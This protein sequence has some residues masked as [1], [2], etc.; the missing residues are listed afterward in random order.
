MNYFDLSG[1]YEFLEGFTARAGV[2]NIFEQNFPISVSG[3]PATNGNNNTF[4]S[5]YDTGRFIF[6]GVNAKL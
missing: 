4:P 6:F 2:N 5:I 3:G 1:S